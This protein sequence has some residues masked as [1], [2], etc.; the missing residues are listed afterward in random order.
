MEHKGVCIGGGGV[1]EI[2]HILDF[3]LTICENDYV[4]K[5]SKY[6]F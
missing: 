5:I 3:F 4:V 2:T 6:D 1:E